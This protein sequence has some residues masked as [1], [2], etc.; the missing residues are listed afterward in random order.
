MTGPNQ[1]APGLPL[2]DLL[3]SGSLDE[4]AV[5]RAT[6]DTPDY[7][8]LPWVNVIKVGGQ[9]LIDRGRAAVYP[10]AEVFG[11]RRMIF[12]KDVDGLYTSDPATATGAR[13][14][15]RIS[16]DELIARDLR[17]LPIDRVVPGLIR[18][19]RLATEVQV[20]NGLVRGNLTRALHGE[21][22][23]TIIHK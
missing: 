3:L 21:H 17:T 6:E 16:A 5:C 14:I 12:V 19:A 4:E 10:L 20:I 8:I 2:G 7:P 13:F 9:S 11:T 22:V 1:A 23:G 18:R 15:P